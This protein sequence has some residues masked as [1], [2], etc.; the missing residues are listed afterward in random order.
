[1]ILDRNTIISTGKKSKISGWTYLVFI[2]CF[3]FAAAFSNHEIIKKK[4]QKFLEVP[5]NSF[6][7]TKEDVETV[8]YDFIKKNP[9]I[10]ISSIQDMQKRDYE[11]SLKQ[12]KISLQ[13]KKSEIIGKDREIAPYA[14]NENGDVVVVT[15]LD[16]RCGYCR[17]A[18]EYLKELVKKDPNVKVVFKEHPVLGE[19]SKKLAKT[20]LAVY[21]IDPSKYVQFHNVIMSSN[22]A[23][24]QFILNTFKLLGIDHI[25]VKELLD[26]P[27]INKEIADVDI[28]CKEIG[29]RGTPAFIIN[30]ELI[31]GAIDVNTMMDLVQKTR[32]AQKEKK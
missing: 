10:I 26:D 31:P 28:L 7:F 5:A 1:M 13:N 6:V 18:N 25:K 22:E 14:G 11:E 2:L 16:Y 9:Q 20:A 27:R 3:L 8:V 30:D 32:E 19:A 21:L 24:D 12:V 17:K 23:N 15:F 4:L 29:V